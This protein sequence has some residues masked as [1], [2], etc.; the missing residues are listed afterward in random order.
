MTE[1]TQ[2]QFRIHLPSGVSWLEKTEDEAMQTA[3]RF[4]YEC[5]GETIL[6]ETVIGYAT[7][8]MP[9]RV[10]PVFTFLSAE[11][12][13]RL[14][15]QLNEVVAETTATP[16]TTPDAAPSTATAAPTS[17]PLGRTTTTEA[18]VTV[19]TFGTVQP[20]AAVPAT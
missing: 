13:E 17:A 16:S 1:Q 12:I 18:G 8:S 5:P 6:I 7:V 15:A 9:Q 3:R 10:E 2:P 20:P 11:N 4:S 14:T 19:A